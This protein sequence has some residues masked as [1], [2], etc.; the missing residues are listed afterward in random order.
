MRIVVPRE[1]APGERRVALA[2]ESCRKL[3]QAGYAIAIESNA[4]N[5]AGFPDAMY[6]EAGVAL[7]PDPATLV[8]S[9][10]IVLKV[11]SPSVEPSRDEVEWMRPGTIYVGSLM[12]L[13]NLDAVRPLRAGELSLAV[14]RTHWSRARRLPSKPAA[15]ESAR[16]AVFLELTQQLPQFFLVDRSLPE[17]AVKS[18][19]GFGVPS[20]FS[21]FHRHL[22]PPERLTFPT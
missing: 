7:E 22:S 8:G 13:R 2:P 5:A 1:T 11:T 6:Q 21:F 14:R 4:G 15:I 12:P 9:A 17:F 18:G 20:A 19:H 3:N 10:D 16:P